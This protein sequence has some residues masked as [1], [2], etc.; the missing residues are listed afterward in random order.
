VRGGREKYPGPDVDD[1]DDDDGT[2][3]RRDVKSG[4]S[5]GERGS[6]VSKELELKGVERIDGLKGRERELSEGSIFFG[7][8]IGQSTKYEYGCQ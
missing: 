8:H 1:D 5:R 6:M 4:K 3:C 2:E 7:R